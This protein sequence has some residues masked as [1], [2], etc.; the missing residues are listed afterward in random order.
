VL[1]LK[2][3]MDLQRKAMD[4]LAEDAEDPRQRYGV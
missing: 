2:A 4:A 1:A 3:K